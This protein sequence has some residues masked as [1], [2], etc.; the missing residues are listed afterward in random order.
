LNPFFKVLS[1]TSHSVLS[2]HSDFRWDGPFDNRIFPGPDPTS[3]VVPIRSSFSLRPTHEYLHADRIRAYFPV[4]LHRV[5][6]RPFIHFCCPVREAVAPGADAGCACAHGV[7]PGLSA[8]TMPFSRRR[9]CPVR[10]GALFRG[11]IQ[12]AGLRC[13]C[14]LMRPFCWLL[15]RLC[16]APPLARR[17]RGR[18]RA[19]LHCRGCLQRWAG[20]GGAGDAFERCA[21]CR[22]AADGCPGRARVPARGGG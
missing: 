15:T 12:G 10:S 8:G 19:P 20:L 3:P 6:L 16:R 17:F 7:L 1:D 5:P 4:P 18:L 21:L 13:G 11:R 9:A 14:T 2:N 22:C